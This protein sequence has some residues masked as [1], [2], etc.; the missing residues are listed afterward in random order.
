MNYL[1]LIIVIIFF[2]LLLKFNVLLIKVNESYTNNYILFLDNN[3][4]YEKLKENKD[5]FLSAI[6]YLHEHKEQ[7]DIVVKLSVA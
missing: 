4:L 5:N 7:K 2:L 3:Q 1:L 6:K